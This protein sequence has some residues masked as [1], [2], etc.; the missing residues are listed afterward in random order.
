MSVQVKKRTEEIVLDAL[1]EG[2]S[3]IPEIMR[4]TKLP[5]GT[6]RYHL[7]MLACKGKVRRIQAG[8][9]LVKWELVEANSSG[10]R[11]RG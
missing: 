6:V 10:K 5:K 11:G 7:F 4:K 3:L 2:C 1:R 9:R 8:K